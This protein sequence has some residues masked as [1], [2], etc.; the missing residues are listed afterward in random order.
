MI[1]EALLNWVSEYLTS[2][3]A[4]KMKEGISLFGRLAPIFSEAPNQSILQ[5]FSHYLLARAFEARYC[6]SIY[7]FFLR[8]TTSA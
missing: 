1:S 3:M 7:Y 8:I 5:V 2:D 4:V 6:Q